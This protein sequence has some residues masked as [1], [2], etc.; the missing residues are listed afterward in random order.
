MSWIRGPP[1]L[2]DSL[3]GRVSNLVVHF[4]DVALLVEVMLLFVEVDQFLVQRLI[5]QLEILRTSLD[6][7][8]FPERNLSSSDVVQHILDFDC[9][10]TSSACSAGRLS[11]A[12]NSYTCSSRLHTHVVTSVTKLSR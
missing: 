6:I 7:A 5:E 12:R 4:C 1:S 3:N 11:S 2:S 10:V 9:C 8:V